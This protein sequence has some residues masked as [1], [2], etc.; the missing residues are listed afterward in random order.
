MR[1]RAAWYRPADRN[2]EVRSGL[3]FVRGLAPQPKLIWAVA[4]GA[5]LIALAVASP[6]LGFLAL[7]YHIGLVVIAARDLALVPGRTGYVVR[8][9]VPEPFSLGEPELVTIVVENHA[10]AGLWASIADHRPA[11][12]RPGPR[13]V[14]SPF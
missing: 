2:L 12:L 9:A 7:V 6:L 13:G 1:S 11:G 10:A 8:R 3:D 5:A 14:S 4:I